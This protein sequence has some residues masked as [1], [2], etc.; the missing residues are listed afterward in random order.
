MSL[1]DNF[2]GF[3]LVRSCHNRPS[4]Y[5]HGARS[6]YSTV[7]NDPVDAVQVLEQARSKCRM[8]SPPLPARTMQRCT[9][10]TCT[11]EK[12]K[13][14]AG[15]LMRTIEATL[16]ATLLRPLPLQSHVQNAGHL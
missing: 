6:R 7:R 10:P 13:V 1:G 12:M 5:R 11:A 15:S 16:H 2:G 14:L 4:Q 8:I 3:C 9:F